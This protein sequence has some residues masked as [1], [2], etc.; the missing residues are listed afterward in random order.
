M[1]MGRFGKSMWCKMLIMNANHFSKC[2]TF[3]CWVKLACQ[4]SRISGGIWRARG[5][6]INFMNRCKVTR[7]EFIENDVPRKVIFALEITNSE[8]SKTGGSGCRKSHWRKERWQKMMALMVC[9]D[10]TRLS[11]GKCMIVCFSLKWVCMHFSCMTPT[12]RRFNGAS[13]ASKQSW[14][15]RMICCWPNGTRNL[16]SPCAS[17]F[18]MPQLAVLT[19]TASSSLY[20][21]KRAWSQM[22]WFVQPELSIMLKE[23]VID[24]QDTGNSNGRSSD[25]DEKAYEE[26][27]P[28]SYQSR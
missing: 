7:P 14:R 6:F 15:V 24:A 13:G 12:E 25:K 18:R 4:T 10:K 22:M 3:W 1:M 5:G 16:T 20:V 11:D 26:V 9:Q 28:F 17:I 19:G 27:T 2:L 21:Q 8:L 23:V